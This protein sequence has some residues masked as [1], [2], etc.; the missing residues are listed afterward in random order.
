MMLNEYVQPKLGDLN[1]QREGD[2]VDLYVAMD[3]RCFPRAICRS[4]AFHAKTNAKTGK[5]QGA[6][7][8]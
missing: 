8:L 4:Q 1:S 3:G 5:A 6:S 7:Y 2:V